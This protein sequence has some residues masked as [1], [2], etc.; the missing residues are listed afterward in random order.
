MDMD[1]NA[2]QQAFMSALVT[3]HF[4]VQ[5]TA[6]STISESSSRA[7][8][9]LLSLSSS[10]VALGFA[11]QASRDAFAPFAAVVL[12]TLFL[13]GWFTVVRLVDTS[14]VNAQCLR[15]IAL[16][17]SYYADLTPEGKQF[18]S[19]SS[20][21]SQESQKMIGIRPGRFVLWFTMA[22]MIGVVNAVLGGA[23]V[24]LLLA[25]GFGV[26]V[27]VAVVLGVIVA[28]A[29]AIVAVRYERHRF[30]LALPD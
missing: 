14:I 25:V 29:S 20:T 3:E 15:R 19:S 5:S 6:S 17:H 4:A 27:G 22:A 10:L 9:Y 30:N 24:A 7:S 23:M 28:V 8:L 21:A 26:T 18:F 12:P 1:E 2:R 16:I 11:T 13:L